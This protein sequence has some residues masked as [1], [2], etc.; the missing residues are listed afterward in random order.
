MTLYE[1]CRDLYAETNGE[2]FV[3]RVNVLSDDVGEK[4]G[5]TYDGQFMRFGGVSGHV[6]DVPVYLG[7]EKVLGYTVDLC[8]PDLDQYNVTIDI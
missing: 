8:G 5:H 3:C 2:N 1:L 6:S 7:G 4:Y